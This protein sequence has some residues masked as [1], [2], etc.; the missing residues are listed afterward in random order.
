MGKQVSS[1]AILV[2][3]VKDIYF[4]PQTLDIPQ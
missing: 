4:L 3:G 2:V 1:V